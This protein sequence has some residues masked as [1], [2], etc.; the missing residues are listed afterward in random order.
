MDILRIF[1]MNEP[2]SKELLSKKDELGQ[3]KEVVQEKDVLL[4]NHRARIKELEKEVADL[5]ARDAKLENHSRIVED[6]EFQKVMGDYD[7]L[8]H[9]V[10]NER[11]HL[12]NK[13]ETLERH[14]QNLEESFSNLLD[15]LAKSRM[16]IENLMENQEVM[17]S[18]L[19]QYKD[20]I[21]VLEEKYNSLKKYSESKIAEA[22]SDIET[23]EKGNIQE[24]AMLKAKILQ[25]QAKINELEKYVKFEDISKRQ[26][27]FEPLKSNITKF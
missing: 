5:K 11:E 1:R 2:V 19:T 15:K 14:V 6:S 4:K 16:V 7:E 10:W 17:K 23:R 20:T 3:Y 13:N 9:R 24:V 12:L 27:M 22:N 18:E 26:S 25:S 8:F 21:H